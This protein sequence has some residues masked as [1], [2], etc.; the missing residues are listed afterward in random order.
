[1]KK[2]YAFIIAA[3][4]TIS[5]SAQI[6]VVNDGVVCNT[7]EPIVVKAVEEA[8]ELED[9]TF[10][11]RVEC[12]T[13]QPVLK[14]EGSSKAHVK[15]TIKSD[16]WKNIMWCGLINQCGPMFSDTEVREGSIA[17][18]EESPIQIEGSFAG[19]PESYGTY[20]VTFTVESNG[21]SDTYEL[22]LVY[23]ESCTAGISEITTDNSSNK[24]IYD[25]SGRRVNHI[26]SGQIYIRDG[27]K[28]IAR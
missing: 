19:G 6:V 8:F 7:K 16:D 12:G 15:V 25:I 20:K 3:M 4:A 14:N 28:F 2:L 26:N 17:A 9:G 21:K 5:A 24:A 10:F 18:G 13:Q 22:H 1:M 27:K 23:D 11:Y